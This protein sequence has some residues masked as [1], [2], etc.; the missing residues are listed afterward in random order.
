MIEITRD[1]IEDVLLHVKKRHGHDFLN[2]SEAS[3]KRRIT[4]FMGLCKIKSSV[5]L[6][7]QLINNTQVFSRFVD[8]IPVMH[9]EM[10]RDAEL[11]HTLQKEVFPYLATY[12]HPK[13]WHAACATGE[14]VYSVAIFLKEIKLLARCRIY[15]TDINQKGLNTA[16]KGRYPLKSLKV[17]QENY[18]LAQGQKSLSDYYT[19]DG[20]YMQMA[21]ELRKPVIFSFHNLVTDGSFNEFNLIFCRNVLIYF[22]LELQNK[23][24]RLLHNSL[25]PKGY[26]VLGNR[27]SMH[28][29]E[30]QDK[31]DLIDE[32]ARVY[33]KKI[34]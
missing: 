9:T 13:I 12:P 27:E 15:A 2:Y 5:E 19:T 34:A 17:F 33:R 26:L 11:Y 7:T 10:F 6:K 3:M 8:E 14:E 24:L 32:E 31:Y 25:A 30:L 4:R 28:G 18:Q 1:E 22:N 29:S 21:T 23:V 16:S 20:K